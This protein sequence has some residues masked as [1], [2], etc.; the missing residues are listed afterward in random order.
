MDDASP[1]VAGRCRSRRPRC[2][3]H[4]AGL[5]GAIAALLVRRATLEATIDELVPG[6]PGRTR[7][8]GAAAGTSAGSWSTPRGTTAE[9]RP[10][11]TRSSV[12]K[13][14][15]PRTSSRSAGKRS[16][17]CIA[18]GGDLTAS[19]VHAARSSR[20][21]AS[22]PASAGPPRTPTEPAATTSVRGR[23]NPPGTHAR[24]HPRSYYEQPRQR[25]RSILDSGL[26]GRKPVLRRRRIREYQSDGASRTS[27]DPP[28]LD[29]H[30]ARPV[31]GIWC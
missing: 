29:R 16:S 11:A 21:P 22:S 8:R 23:R 19:V 18:P 13:P 5:L 31:A 1:T 28:P 27:R 9:Q 2:A 25:S 30:D 3:G 14:A 26:S 12:A 4:A 24:E 20:S 6:S 15:N 10:R 17:A 7:S